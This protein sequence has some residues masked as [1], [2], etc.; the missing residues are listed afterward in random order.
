MLASNT[1]GMMTTHQQP[2]MPT[3][4]FPPAAVVVARTPPHTTLTAAAPSSPLL[5]QRG[6]PGETTSMMMMPASTMFGPGTALMGQDDRRM[7][8]VPQQLSGDPSSFSVGN[9]F[10]VDH[11]YN[12][13]NLAGLHPT[14]SVPL[15]QHHAHM[16]FASGRLQNMNNNNNNVFQLGL[17]GYPM[18]LNATHMMQLHQIQAAAAVNQASPYLLGTV[19]GLPSSS[20]SFV[21]APAAM[22][23]GASM[24][25]T[26]LPSSPLVAMKRIISDE[27][28]VGT[29]RLRATESETMTQSEI[30]SDDSHSESKVSEDDEA[31]SGATRTASS[32]SL[33]SANGVPRVKGPWT[34]KEDTMLKQLVRQYGKRWSL[35][36]EKLPGRIGKQCRERWLNHLDPKINR[37]PWTA[38]EA[39]S[40]THLTLPTKRIV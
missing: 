24:I 14:S 29:K 28:G 10:V 32:N 38:A 23:A 18:P 5:P 26:S 6:H 21:A 13:N 12:N 33:V 35:V 19:A 11:L 15:H 31:A 36:A 40:Y 27:S 4:G 7:V 1:K 9:G 30:E 34:I 22:R 3:R 25:S 8:E 2:T 20:R 39:V 16:M 37:N 17:H